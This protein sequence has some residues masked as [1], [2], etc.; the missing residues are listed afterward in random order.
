MGSPPRVRGTGKRP[1]RCEHNGR[2]TPACAGNRDIINALLAE[3]KDHPRVCGEQQ[4]KYLKRK[5]MMGSPPRVRG[6]GQSCIII[7]KKDRIT[8]ACAGNRRPS[9]CWREWSPDHPRVCGEQVSELW[10]FVPVKGSPPRVRGTAGAQ[11][12]RRARFGITPACAG[13]RTPPSL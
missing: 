5:Q 3:I 1:I 6:T 8:P 9:G 13:N 12:G 2:I 7:A 10:E 4:V 11:H